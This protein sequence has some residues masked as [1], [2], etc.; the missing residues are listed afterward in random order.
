VENNKETK[1]QDQKKLKITNLNTSTTTKE[2]FMSSTSSKDEI[3]NH[4]YYIN[5]LT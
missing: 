4:N 5:L 2:D 1:H 3:G